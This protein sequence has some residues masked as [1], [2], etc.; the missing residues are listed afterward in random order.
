MR[1]GAPVLSR[2]PCPAIL[3][4]R[5]GP[6]FGG[7]ARTVPK[8]CLRSG[9]VRGLGALRPLNDLERHALTLGQRL[10]PVHRDRGEVHED[11]LATLTLD[12]AVALLVRKPLHCALRQLLFLLGTATARGTSRRRGLK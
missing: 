12:E 2:W 9:D 8:E 4:K 11:V 5:P 10:V 6:P 7:P 1:R 3:P